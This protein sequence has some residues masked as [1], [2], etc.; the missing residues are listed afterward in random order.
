MKNKSHSRNNINEVVHAITVMDIELLY[1]SLDKKVS[2]Q[3]V[4]IAIF[5]ERLEIV[6][7]MFR[8]E[9][10]FLIPHQGKCHSGECSNT[11]KS[12]FSFTGNVSG[13]YLNL[14]IEKDINENVT[15]MY[16]CH[17]FCPADF[18]LDHSKEEGYIKVY[19]DE[20]VDF[21][22]TKTFEH[23]SSLAENS[24]TEL[25]LFK[26]TTMPF[27]YIKLWTEKYANLY[28]IV[29]GW[30]S[31]KTFILFNNYYQSFENLCEIVEVE[32]QAKVAVSDFIKLE[33]SN[34]EI[35]LLNWIVKYEDL[36]GKLL[37]HDYT[38]DKNES[39]E[40]QKRKI[41][42]DLNVYF[43]LQIIENCLKF[44][45][46]FYSVYGK[47][48]EKYNTLTYDEIDLMFDNEHEDIDH[49]YNVSY[50]LKKRGIVL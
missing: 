42:N 17:S 20:K 46:L 25:N 6:F 32:Q 40:V 12:G 16:Q 50:H 30:F 2:Y 36:D 3:K 4:P 47:M 19:K 7:V 41:N 22:R 31:I 13:N 45:N 8:N 28:S 29:G 18:Q 15:D 49:V 34:S 48:L 24:I 10:T 9:D 44:H 39:I 35:D 37:L 26:E 21:V 5:L 23:Y 38:I 14:I 1:S 27:D 33:E 11:N 43:S